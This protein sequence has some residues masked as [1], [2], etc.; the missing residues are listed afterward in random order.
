MMI[1]RSIVIFL[2]IIIVSSI[3]VFIQYSK[4]SK[5]FP[6][7]ESQMLNSTT[8]EQ[9]VKKNGYVLTP[10]IINKMLGIEKYNRVLKKDGEGEKPIAVAVLDS[11]VYPH[12]DLTQPTNKIIAFKDFVNHY[13]EP[14][15]DYGH[16]TFISGLIAGGSS[17]FK[18]ISPTVNIVGVKVLDNVGEGSL[19]NTING[20]NW[21]I[22]NKEK[23]NIRVINISYGF[24]ELSFDSLNDLEAAIITADEAGLVIVSSI[25]NKVIKD[26]VELIDSPTYPSAFE[27]VLSVG[28]MDYVTNETVF[29]SY[30]YKTAPYTITFMN[31]ML[32]TEPDF[33]LPGTKI[34]SLNSDNEYLPSDEKELIKKYKVE[35]GASLSAAILSG[36]IARLFEQ[37]PNKSN[38]EIKELVLEN[39]YPILNN[40]YTKQKQYLYFEEGIGE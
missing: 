4:T 13:A 39:R 36:V 40:N 6:P 30:S 2:L 35:N 12:Q 10:M 26:A 20:I 7:N 29:S 18:G 9:L 38:L 23:Y 24:N 27:R 15:D 14:Y 33:I 37:F 8:Y 28:A 22:K 1:R 5:R 32:E 21:I 11:G 17:N 16:G 3:V 31:K 34:L 25:G 19:S